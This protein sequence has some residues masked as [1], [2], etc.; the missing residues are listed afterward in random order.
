MLDEREKPGFL[1]ARR[2]YLPC[3]GV[4]SEAGYHTEAKKPGFFPTLQQPYRLSG[5]SLTRCQFYDKL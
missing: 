3:M 4:A 1:L 5:P 2:W